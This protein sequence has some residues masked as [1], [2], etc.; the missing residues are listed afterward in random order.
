MGSSL[1]RASDWL[2]LFWPR[3]PHQGNKVAKSPGTQEWSIL[4]VVPP[5]PL[6]PPDGWINHQ[7]D[8]RQLQA[9]NSL[10]SA[11][12][13]MWTVTFISQGLTSRSHLLFCRLICVFCSLKRWHC[14]LCSQGFRAVKHPRMIIL[15]QGEQSASWE[16]LCQNKNLLTQLISRPPLSPVLTPE[17]KTMRWSLGFS[18]KEICY[19]R[20]C[21]AAVYGPFSLG[22]T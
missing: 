14:L 3:W 19:C 9:V 21:C 6:P 22:S 1:R 20:I 13:P 2:A 4:S 8:K 7:S 12:Q 18:Y 15:I 17:E 11:L 5:S 10:I 16:Q